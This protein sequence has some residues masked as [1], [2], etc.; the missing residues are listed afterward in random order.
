[1]PDV[2]D[3]LLDFW[4]TN[5]TS[6]AAHKATGLEIDEWERRYE[7][8]LPTDL[9]E[10]VTRVNG[11]FN[12]EA[13]EFDDELISFLPLSAMCPEDKWWPN[14]RARPGM[15]IFADYLISSSWWCAAL[16]S[17]AHEHTRIFLGG[18]AGENRL[19]ASSLAEFFD[20]YMNRSSRLH[21]N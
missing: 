1:M 11:T 2:L 17:S 13:L 12:G 9:R 19:I 14:L 15:F 5:G 18:G 21:G 8:I 6:P 10:Y 4:K 7:V 20:L 16:D 3:A